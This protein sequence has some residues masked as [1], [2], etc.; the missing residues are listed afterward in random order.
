VL[1]HVF[2]QRNASDEVIFG[3]EPFNNVPT[4]VRAAIVDKDKLE[5]IR[6]VAPADDV[7]NLLSKLV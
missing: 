1:T 2:S 7:T 5:T 3:R 6:K 4:V